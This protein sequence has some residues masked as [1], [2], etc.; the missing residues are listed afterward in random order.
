ME[1]GKPGQLRRV[2]NPE[3]TS[4]CEHLEEEDSEGHQC[5]LI[6]RRK[7]TE[8]FTQHLSTAGKY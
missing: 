7:Q 5:L 2:V 3:A 1:S 8:G 6:K 4:G